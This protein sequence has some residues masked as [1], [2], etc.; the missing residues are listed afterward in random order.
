MATAAVVMSALA[1]ASSVMQGYSAYRQGKADQKT[2]NA[3]AEIYAANARNKRIETS[4]AE[5]LKR[6]ENRQRLS[7]MRAGM[8]E[9]NMLSSATSSGVLASS[10]SAGEADALNLRYKGENEAI[11]Y[12]NQENLNRYLGRQAYESGKSAFQMSFLQG[13]IGSAFAYASAG[14][15]FGSLGGAE[16]AAPKWQI[17]GVRPF[18]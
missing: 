3:N 13:A 10:A 14:G 7:A 16:T 11:N 4:L 15:T 12:L 8:A 1:M 9:N 5:D 6:K 2:Y 18:A 17:G